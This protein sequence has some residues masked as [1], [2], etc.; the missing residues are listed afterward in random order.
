[1]QTQLSRQDKERIILIK[2]CQKLAD[3]QS[4]SDKEVSEWYYWLTTLGSK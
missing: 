3:I 4:M 1:M 2:S